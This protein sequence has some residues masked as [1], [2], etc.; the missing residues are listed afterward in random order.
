MCSVS[1]EQF[2]QCTF[3]HVSVAGELVGKPQQIRGELAVKNLQ[4]QSA[5]S[6]TESAILSV[7]VSAKEFA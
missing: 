7:K 4:F 5:M 3:E 2:L 1:S 6:A